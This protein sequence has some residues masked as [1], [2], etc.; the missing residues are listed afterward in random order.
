M[1]TVLQRVYKGVPYKIELGKDGWEMEGKTFTSLTAAA[2]QVT[3]YKAI[4]GRDF[5]ARNGKKE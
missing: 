1:G 4:N 3:G 2:K 5:F